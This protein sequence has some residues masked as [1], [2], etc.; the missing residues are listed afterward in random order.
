MLNASS[1]KILK[2]ILGLLTNR[3]ACGCFA[4]LTFQQI[5][6]ASSTVW[7][8]T[9]MKRIT[10]GEP[11]F[12]F[13]FLY[14]G[15]LVLPYIPGCLANIFKISWKQESQRS[16][17]HA[18]V[19]SNRNQI[20]E[21]SNK[22]IKEEKLSILT[23]EGPSALQALIDYIFDL[24]AYVLS[25]FFN[26]FALSVIVEPLFGIAYSLSVLTVVFVMK[27]KRRFQRRLTQKALTA[28][29]D[30]C[31][32][33][34][35]A[36][37]NVLLGNF[38]NFKLWQD[39]TAQ[40]VNRC[41]QKNVELERF[42]QVLAIVIS[43]LT[44]IPSL[45]VVVYYVYLNQTSIPNLTSFLVTL[46]VLFQILSYTY[47][48]L[49]LIFRWTMHRSKLVSI[50]KAIQP[51]QNSN[52]AMEKKIK[53]PKIQIVNSPLAT[54]DFDHVSLAGPRSISSYQELLDYTTRSGRVTLRGEN[55]AGKSTLLML[56]KN[57]LI[58]RAFFLPTQ[59]Q[60]SFISEANKYSTGESLRNRLL[61]ILEKVDV[62]VLL[63]DEWDANLD[64]ENQERLSSLI[65]ELAEKK[66]VIEV[67]HR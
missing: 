45:I 44:S 58:D 51:I 30:L 38:Y 36:W 43:L 27:A 62:D 35:A 29:I 59:N 22:G 34:L 65:D 56:I 40:R 26:I 61:E 25:V 24:Y 20:G 2:Q 57:S 63:L 18:F 23:A 16:F 42:D 21:W 46:P 6:E 64:K 15:S 48:T 55:G 19:T 33:L 4:L 9:M 8:V 10:S 14:L 50:Y 5:I 54:A 47:Q 39:K 31:Q 53:W 12:P 13:L 49:S 66:C 3:W 17:I 7:L 11:F 37:D 67:R 28:R 52:I 1:P 41:L 32:S 60:L